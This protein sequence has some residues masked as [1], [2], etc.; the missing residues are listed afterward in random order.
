MHS[1][2]PSSLAELRRKRAKQTQKFPCDFFI[3]FPS[4]GGGGSKRVDFSV[5]C[6][7]N[8]FNSTKRKAFNDFHSFR[9][10][11]RVVVDACYWHFGNKTYIQLSTIVSSLRLLNRNEFVSLSF[12]YLL[13]L[14]KIRTLSRSF[15]S[16]HF[17]FQ[18]NCHWTLSL[19]VWLNLKSFNF[20]PFHTRITIRE[21]YQSP[22]FHTILRGKF[23]SIKH[24]AQRLP[25]MEG[26]E[27]KCPFLVCVC[28]RTMGKF[29]PTQ[30]RFHFEDNKFVKCFGQISWLFSWTF[31]RI[32]FHFIEICFLFKFSRLSRRKFDDLHTKW[33]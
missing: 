10:V 17:H 19:K 15:L 14:L 13:V 20:S 25:I 11:C 21:R 27:R 32:L 18:F 33:F 28:T 7:Q 9:D 6:G 22:N 12:F 8:F 16:F 3:F 4:D 5:F 31:T 26:N 23:F 29:S 30:T 2:E 24:P 1:C